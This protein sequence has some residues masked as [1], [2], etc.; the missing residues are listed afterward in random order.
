MLSASGLAGGPRRAVSH[1][2]YPLCLSLSSSEPD[3]LPHSPTHPATTPNV[4]PKAE[5]AAGS[6]REDKAGMH[7]PE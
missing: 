3:L 6:S 7:G 2:Q 4:H 5:S 1:A